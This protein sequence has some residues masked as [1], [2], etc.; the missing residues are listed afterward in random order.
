[1]GN[2]RDWISNFCESTIFTRD[3]KCQ[4]YLKFSVKLETRIQELSKTTGFV[5]LLVAT[6]RSVQ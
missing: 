3:E 1:M 2:E 4:T 5:I 6:T